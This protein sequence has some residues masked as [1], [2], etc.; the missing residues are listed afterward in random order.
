[1]E[2]IPS[3][4]A[5]N[6]DYDDTNYGTVDGS[7]SSGSNNEETQPPQQQHSLDDDVDKSSRNNNNN[8]NKVAFNVQLQQIRQQIK[9]KA[10]QALRD[11]EE[12][13]NDGAIRLCEEMYKHDNNLHEAAFGEHTGLH[14]K[15]QG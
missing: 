15:M 14:N 12:Q 5:N 2:P 13:F 11:H 9:A 4:S 6:N 8:N 1:M 10:K 3:T 7:N